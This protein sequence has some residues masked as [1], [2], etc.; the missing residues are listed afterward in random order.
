LIHNDRVVGGVTT[1][2]TLKAKEIIESISLG[3]VYTTDSRTAEA[4]K[5]IENTYRDVN[6]A[7]AN[8]LELVSRDLKFNI[9]QAIELANKHPRVNVLQPGPG[10]GGHCIAVDPWF[11]CEGTKHAKLIRQARKI[12]DERP[13]VIVSDVHE[14]CKK[15]NYKKIL[16]LG[17]AYKKNV[18]DCRETPAEH[19]VQGLMEKGY[20]LKIHDAHAT[21]WIHPLEKDLKFAENWADCIVLITDHDEYINLKTNKII[22]DTRN[23]MEKNYD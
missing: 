5:L 4:V 13:H 10:V 22:V 12:N 1:E 9:W 11:L 16:V 17:V 21:R 14:I 6:I 18:D 7:L 3:N 8:E 20:Q 19:V 15:N 23:F 2:A